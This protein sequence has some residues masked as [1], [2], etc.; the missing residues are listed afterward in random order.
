MERIGPIFIQSD[1]HALGGAIGPRCAKVG[2]GAKGQFAGPI[3]N[4]IIA[5]PPRWVIK[6]PRGGAPQLGV[7]GRVPHEWIQLVHD[8]PG[9]RQTIAIAVKCAASGIHH[10]GDRS[11]IVGIKHKRGTS[12]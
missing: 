7:F 10:A 3:N 5:G 8:F 12:P 4:Q 2:A 1:R 9:I 6:A 11:R